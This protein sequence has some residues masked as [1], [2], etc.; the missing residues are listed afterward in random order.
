MNYTLR[1]R[2][3]L[4]TLALLT[5]A[6]VVFSVLNFQQRSAF[7]SPDDGVSWTDTPAG[8]Q[9]WQVLP[10]SPAENAGLRTGDIL[11]KINGIPVRSAT[12]VER[13][14]WRAGV[15][16]QLTYTV[17]RSNSLFDVKLITVPASTPN[18]FENYI[19]LMG[20][21]YLFIGLF[22]FV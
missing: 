13:R 12:Q 7:V 9:V 6:A 21:L 4:V 8:V 11:E 20:L 17:Q 10:G 22:I 16:S 18:R 19:R 1:M 3:G 15:W 2:L 14:I 5:V